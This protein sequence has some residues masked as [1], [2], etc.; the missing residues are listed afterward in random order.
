MGGGVER[1][2]EVERGLR[3]ERDWGG[4]KGMPCNHNRE[5]R[6]ATNSLN[7]T[8]RYQPHPPMEHRTKN[9]D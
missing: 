9:G 7:D 5:G 4:A 8:G 2:K 6:D 3:G 1:Q